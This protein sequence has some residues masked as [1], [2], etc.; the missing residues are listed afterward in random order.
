MVPIPF[1]LKSKITRWLAGRQCR[2]L[3]MLLLTLCTA[4]TLAAFSFLKNARLLS[5]LRTFVN[6][7]LSSSNSLPSS[8][9]SHCQPLLGDLALILQDS[10]SFLDPRNRLRWVCYII[11]YPSG[12][13]C[14]TFHNYNKLICSPISCL[15][16]L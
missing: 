4:I 15:G 2:T 11:S 14:S 7:P 6:V 12:F 13:L 8:S 1:R 5:H 10:D 9:P 16:F 3:S